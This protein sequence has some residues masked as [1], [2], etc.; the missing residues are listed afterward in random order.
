MFE[1]MFTIVPIMV[2]CIFIFTFAMVLS[3]KLRG[4][5][6]SRQLKA[7]KYMFDESKEDLAEIAT[8]AGNV[9]INSRKNI[10]DANEDTLRDITT[11]SANIN[12]EGIEITARAIKDGLTG[13]TI[14]CKHCGKSIDEDSKFCKFCGKEQ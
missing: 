1:L 13:T 6:M 9:S 2:I 4:K 3:P 5:F 12:K 14:F 10:L 8:I 7:T 11:R